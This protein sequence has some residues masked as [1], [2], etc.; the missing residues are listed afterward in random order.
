MQ[1]I[2]QIGKKS[3]GALYLSPKLILHFTVGRV[4]LSGNDVIISSVLMHALKDWVEDCAPEHGFSV[5]IKFFGFE[6]VSLQPHTLDIFFF[7]LKGK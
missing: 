3:T 4:E 5:A 7:F 1:N 6:I 2:S